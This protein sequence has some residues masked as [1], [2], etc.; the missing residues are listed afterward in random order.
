[1]KYIKQYELFDFLKNEDD[2]PIGNIFA[3]NS[4]DILQKY[5][6]GDISLTHTMNILYDYGSN[7]Y[8]ELGK[9]IVDSYE[10]NNIKIPE[11]YKST[12]DKRGK[13]KDTY[14]FIGNF[15]FTGDIIKYLDDMFGNAVRH[16]EFG[17]GDDSFDGYQCV[18]YFIRINGF[19]YHINYDHRGMSISVS[20]KANT[21]EVINGLKLIINR[22]FEVVK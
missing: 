1:M 7:A 5:V 21:K 9:Y 13:N 14:R 15:F 22:F 10:K 20:D 2:K 18:S 19:I 4:E 3:L 12:L 8:S 6:A 16:S 17:E 11:R